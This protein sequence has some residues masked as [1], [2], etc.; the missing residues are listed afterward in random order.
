V[1]WN[2]SAGSR[3]ATFSSACSGPRARHHVPAG[4]QQHAL[5]PGLRG[6][7]KASWCGCLT[8][9]SSEDSRA[10]SS[11]PSSQQGLSVGRARRRRGAAASDGHLAAAAH[12][13]REPAFGRRWTPQEPGPQALSARR[14]AARRG[15]RKPSLRADRSLPLARSPG[16]TL[17]LARARAWSAP[18]CRTP[19]A[20][21]AAPDPRVIPEPVGSPER[22]GRC[23]AG[24]LHPQHRR[25]AVAAVPDHFGGALSKPLVCRKRPV[26]GISTTHIAVPAD[27]PC[28]AACA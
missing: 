28:C 9:T 18:R 20:L 12:P 22:D 15:P 3:S 26:R 10:R 16:A 7:A 5:Q 2:N 8:V 13:L 1:I 4:R 21:A 19:R 27:G 24:V 11:T 23:Q 6:W 25:G 17:T 14:E